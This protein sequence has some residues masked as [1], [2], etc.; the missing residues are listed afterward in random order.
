GAAVLVNARTDRAGVEETVAMVAKRGGRALGHL[1]DVTDERAV[2]AM[3]DAAVAAFGRIDILVNNAA[4][5]RS[6][7]FET[8]TVAQWRE[9]VGVTLDGAFLCARA[10]VPHMLKVGGGSIVSIGGRSGHTGAALRAHVVA[11]KTGLVGLMRALAIEYAEKGVT[12]NCVV[13]GTIDT[14]RGASAG[15]PGQ[16]PGGELPPMQRKGRPE[17]V[18]ALVRHLCLPESRYITGQAIH[19]SGGAYLP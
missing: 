4:I 15:G 1:A 6:Q 9:V 14:T 10:A 7:A 16:H 12:A 19:V 8:M 11:A 13:P 5:R 18:S 2:Q 17:E 3:V